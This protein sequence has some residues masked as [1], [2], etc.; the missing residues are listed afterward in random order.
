MVRRRHRRRHCRRWP[1]LEK[2]FYRFDVRKSCV[3]M[4]R[5][6]GNRPYGPKFIFQYYYSMIHATINV[7]CVTN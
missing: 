6:A 5:G 4:K 1:Q 3:Y 2:I 7:F